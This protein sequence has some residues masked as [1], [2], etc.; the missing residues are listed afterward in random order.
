MRLANSVATAKDEAEFCA[1][2][3]RFARTHPHI[4]SQMMEGFANPPPP[5]IEATQ[6]MITAAQRTFG[7]DEAAKRAWLI[8]HG[9]LVLH[10]NGKLRARSERELEQFLI[11]LAVS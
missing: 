1:H 9:G 8:L 11:S 3:I 10:A 5:L 4:Y 6:R 7:S 2:Y